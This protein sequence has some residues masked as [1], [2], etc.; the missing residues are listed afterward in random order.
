MLIRPS[1]ACRSH[2]RDSRLNRRSASIVVALAVLLTV[3]LAAPAG[4]YVYWSNNDGAIGRADLDGSAVQPMFL[5]TPQPTGIAASSQYL[6]WNNG[7]GYTVGRAGLDGSEAISSLVGNFTWFGVATNGTHIFYAANQTIGRANLDGS[8]SNPNFIAVNGT[9]CGVAV[10]AAHIYWGDANGWVGR[11]NLDGSNPDPD[12]IAVRG[13]NGACGVAVNSQYVYWGNYLNG[14]SSIGRAN[15]D[16]SAPNLDFITG[17]AG[18][19]GVAVDSAHIYWTNFRGDVGRAN[20]DGTAKN[21]SFIDTISSCGVAV[22]PLRA[23]STTVS[24][25]PGSSTYGADLVIGATVAGVAGGPVPT[26]T[27]QFLVNGTAEDP[28]AAIDASGHVSYD[29]SFYLDV[30]SFIEAVYEGDGVYGS[31]GAQ[32]SPTITPATTVSEL[33]LSPIR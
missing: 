8:A 20:L 13:D 12:W 28:P 6:Y 32:I 16:G 5:P 4:A 17:A 22:D 7:G 2:L 3:A 21:Q 14:G 10:D 24:V 27:V 11:A 18:P 29:P 15:L 31:S 25:S 30:G 26:G 19:C 23:S 9:A 33:A 1:Q